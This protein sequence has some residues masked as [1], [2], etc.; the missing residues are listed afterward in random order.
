[1]C[2]TVDRAI[3]VKNMMELVHTDVRCV[4]LLQVT[5]RGMP[6]NPTRKSDTAKL[7]KIMLLVVLRHE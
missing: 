7:A 5:R 4:A 6:T 2:S 3:N 1:M